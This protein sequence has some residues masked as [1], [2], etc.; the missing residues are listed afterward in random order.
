[1]DGLATVA[2]GSQSSNGAV[3]ERLAGLEATVN[4]FGS[5]LPSVNDGVDQRGDAQ[6][7]TVRTINEIKV[8]FSTTLLSALSPRGEGRGAK[9]RSTVRV[10]LCCWHDNDELACS[11]RELYRV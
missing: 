10:S 7:A 11:A 6:A 9:Y 4:H 5:R 1:M 2:D 8:R 3:L